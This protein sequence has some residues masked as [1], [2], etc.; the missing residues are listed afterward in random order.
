MADPD[1]GAARSRL[2]RRRA[3]SVLS[4]RFL[5]NAEFLKKKKTCRLKGNGTSISGVIRCF[6]GL[7]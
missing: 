6:S 2:L 4:G 3:V 1:F 7:Y 5:P